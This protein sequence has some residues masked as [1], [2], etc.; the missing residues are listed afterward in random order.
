[1]INPNMMMGQMQD[2]PTTKE[3]WKDEKSKYRHW[4]ILFGVSLL[5]IFSLLLTS[6]ILNLA[7]ENS[8]K[9]A[10]INW[11]I[12]PDGQLTGNV[13]FNAASIQGKTNAQLLSLVSDW[14]NN[15]YTRNTLTLGSIQIVI[16]FIG[17]V[18]YFYSIYESYKKQSFAKISKVATFVVGIGALIGFFK[19][20]SLMTNNSNRIIFEYPE[21][22]YEFI[23]W[24][25][26]LLIF[27]FISIPLNKIRRSF[28]ISERYEAFKNSPQYE[29]YK[30]Q[31]DAM[32]NGQFNPGM[33]GMGSMGP[34]GPINQPTNQAAAQPNTQPNNS[35]PNPVKKELTK[36]EKK[37]AELSKMRIV[38][39]KKIA[40]KL[41][42]SGYTSMKKTELVNAILRLTESDK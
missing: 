13:G 34:F 5:V 20:F 40:K 14:A 6:F 29:M 15:Y 36:K 35:N 1:M 4:I 38:D 18:L 33:N 25:L 26:P 10:M 32:K 24:F 28:Q 8:I 21:G 7:N 3:L 2:V 9:Q 12:K 23:L 22:I 19:L 39:L 27:I 31:M 30:Q 37:H 42:I 11:A 16:V 17:V 41:S